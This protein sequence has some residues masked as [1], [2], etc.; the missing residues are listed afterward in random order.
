[1]IDDCEL[2]IA[3]PEI[4]GSLTT[5]L[6]ASIT[7]TSKNHGSEKAIITYEFDKDGYISKILIKAADGSTETYTLTWQ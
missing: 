7:E 4:A 1:M 3:H 2:F 6:P 5:Q